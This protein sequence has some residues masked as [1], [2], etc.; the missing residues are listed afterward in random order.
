L[1]MY[2]SLKK[3]SEL[4]SA[5]IKYGGITALAIIVIEGIIIAVK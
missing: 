5:V 3:R 1:T 2:Q 4:S